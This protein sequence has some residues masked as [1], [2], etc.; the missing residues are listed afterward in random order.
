MAKPV[1]KSIYRTI[2]WN[3]HNAE[4]LRREVEEMRDSLIN[5]SGESLDAGMPKGH[6]K[7][8]DSTALKAVA[9]ADYR[10]ALWLEAIGDTMGY[11]HKH[12]PEGRMAR[13]FYGRTVTVDKVARHMCLD[14]RTV[15]YYRDA[16]VTRCALYATQ[17][18]LI[19]IE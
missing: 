7:H 2:E 14:R 15:L 8:S 4:R 19:V 10:P 18:G 3:L 6:S 9:L 11:Y 16:F 12:T 1:E 13:L 5:S 17:R